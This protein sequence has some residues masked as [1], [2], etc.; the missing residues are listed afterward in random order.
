MRYSNKTFLAV[1]TLFSVFSNL[2]AQSV[3]TKTLSVPNVNGVTWTGGQLVAV[4]RN[5]NVYTSPDGM[6]WSAP[7]SIAGGQYLFSVAGS[8]SQII[9]VGM[10]IY[11][12]PDGTTW[13]P[14]NSGPSN[15]YGVT[16]TGSQYVAV[17]NGIYV[18]SDAAHWTRTSYAGIF[19]S[20]IWTGNQLVAVGANG[21]VMTSPDGI[22]WTVRNSSTTDTL[23]SVT[24]T[25][26]QLVAIGYTTKSEAILTSPDGIT[27][28][29]RDSIFTAGGGDYCGVTWTGNEL[30]A[31]GP[32]SSV[33][34]SPDGVA[35]K[36]STASGVNAQSVIW[37]GNQFVAVGEGGAY[38][39]PPTSTSIAPYSSSKEEGIFRLTA[40]EL[41]IVFPNTMLGQKHV[42]LY[43]VKGDRIL[44]A[45]VSGMNN[46]ISLP[47]SPLA[48][49][50]YF[51]ELDNSRN[52]VM[53]P[54]YITR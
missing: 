47:I 17:G 24:W 32:N 42:A 51:L 10:Y 14:Q 21:A 40:M 44:D 45:N 8:P 19:Y 31:V 36:A 27:W 5:G 38:S 54:L 30:V 4:T 16:W 50:H 29:Q 11:T 48:Q 9:A 20:V 39:A 15:L 2:I 23:N 6:K 43:T 1:V 25:G 53:K 37:T 18:S 28:T 35:W 7:N 3:W 49:G 52:R 12:S 22:A 33:L 13:T 34:T 46:D 26:S 41:S